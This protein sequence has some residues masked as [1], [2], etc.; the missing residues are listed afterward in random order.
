MELTG[1]LPENTEEGNEIEVPETSNPLS[2]EI[3]YELSNTVDPYM[4]VIPMG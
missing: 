4:Q 3:F 1:P 2:E